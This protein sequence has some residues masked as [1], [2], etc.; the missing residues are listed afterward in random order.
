MESWR[1]V[2]R[3]GFA[4]GLPVDALRA[5][6]AG[7][8]DDDRAIL[9]GQATNPL[10]LGQFNGFEL[11]GGDPIVYA[12]WKAGAVATVGEAE[13]AFAT[14]CFEADARLGGPAEC[15]YFLHWCDDAPRHELRRELVAEIKRELKRRAAQPAGA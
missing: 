1:Y 2:W 8:K 12:L 13:Q 7:L 3:E 11:Q 10:P 6:E 4:P 9:Q 15:R 5:L 14:A